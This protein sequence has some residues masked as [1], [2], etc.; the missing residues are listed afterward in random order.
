M[1]KFFSYTSLKAAVFFLCCLFFS[2]EN[3]M[4]DVA[5]IGKKKLSREEALQIESYM[6]QGG[7]MKAKLTAPLMWRTQTDTPKIEFPKTLRVDFY[8]DSTKIESR[9]TAKY[10]RYYERMGTVFLK[11]SVVVINLIKKDTLRCEELNWD[12]D[13]EIFYTDKRVSIHKANGDEV[14]GLGL[15]AKQD[16]SQYTILHVQPNTYLSIPDSTIP[17]K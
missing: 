7:V 1:T 12:R 6:S 5:D 16:F 13:K 11:D 3:K 14:Y 8:T 9:L 15:T 2:C 17:L 4:S 10:G